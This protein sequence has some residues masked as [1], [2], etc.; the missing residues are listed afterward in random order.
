MD[1]KAKAQR[2]D[3]SLE[4]YWVYTTD[5]AYFVV[6]DEILEFIEFSWLNPT[7]VR[8]LEKFAKACKRTPAWRHDVDDLSE[9]LKREGIRNR[10]LEQETVQSLIDSGKLS[11]HDLPEPLTLEERMLR[12]GMTPELIGRNIRRV[13]EARGLTVGELAAK[14]ELDAVEV[15]AYE[16]GLAFIFAEELVRLAKALEI[17]DPEKLLLD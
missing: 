13:R 9:Y 14:A 8:L 11:R 1:G 17:D 10:V 15:L 4:L 16:G 7:L 12:P 6:D 5:G 2:C 3:V